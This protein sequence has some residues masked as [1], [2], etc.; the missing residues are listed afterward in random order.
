MSRETSRTRRV[1]S[2]L[3]RL[4]A[5]LL[6][7][8]FDDPRMAMVSLTAVR[9]SRDLGHARVFVTIVND[10]PRQREELLH[11]L[12]GAAGYLRGRL[13]REM[14]IRVVPRLSFEYD[15]SV[16]RGARLS[17]LIDD[18]VAAD[19]ATGTGSAGDRD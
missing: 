16:I 6:R 9:V 8:E 4:L 5:E 17:Q 11:E 7:T 1:S 15:E 14:R 2:Q 13:G 19:D 3:R 10:T 12:N 18:A